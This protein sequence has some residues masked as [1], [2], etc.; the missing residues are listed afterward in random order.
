MIC[1]YRDVKIGIGGI[2]VFRTK[3]TNGNDYIAN[4]IGMDEQSVLNLYSKHPDKIKLVSCY[5]ENCPT[6]QVV[7]GI[8]NED[9]RVLYVNR[10]FEKHPCAKACPPE[11]SYEAEHTSLWFDNPDI[12]DAYFAVEEPN[13]KEKDNRILCLKMRGGNVASV[14]SKVWHYAG[15]EAQD[16]IDAGEAPCSTCD[17][18]DRMYCGWYNGMYDFGREECHSAPYAIGPIVGHSDDQNGGFDYI[19]LRCE[20]FWRSWYWGLKISFDRITYY[21]KQGQAKEIDVMIHSMPREL[22]KR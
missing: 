9:G 1:S 13:P 19:F 3:D 17:S 4:L 21:S 6:G 18:C 14:A 11:G 20:D 8:D 2:T 15:L 10:K 5:I 12:I 16:L 22:L 7:Y